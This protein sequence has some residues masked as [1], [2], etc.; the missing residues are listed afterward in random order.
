MSQTTFSPLQTTLKPPNTEIAPSQA[1]A[2]RWTF[3][4]STTIRHLNR[5]SVRKI[6]FASLTTLAGNGGKWRYRSFSWIH[7]R[8]STHETRKARYGLLRPFYGGSAMQYCL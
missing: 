2:T 3:L 1:R 4:L 7:A 6:Q 5:C 8:K